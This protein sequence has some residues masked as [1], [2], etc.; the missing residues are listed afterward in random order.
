M[1]IIYIYI[2][3]SM[4]F[5]QKVN[6]H[7]WPSMLFSRKQETNICFVLAF[8]IFHKLNKRKIRVPNIFAKWI[9]KLI[10]WRKTDKDTTWKKGMARGRTT[11]YKTTYNMYLMVISLFPNPCEYVHEVWV[12]RF[13][14]AEAFW[15]IYQ[16]I[17][18]IILAK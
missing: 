8:E 15:Y 10:N 16:K 1:L 4:F 2:Y 11:V 3:M 18:K 9:L 17:N 13:V 5:F 7:I 12:Y 6:K 14:F